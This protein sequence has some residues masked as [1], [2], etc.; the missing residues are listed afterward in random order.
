MKQ[1][2]PIPAGRQVHLPWLDGLRG[3]AALWVLASHV[4]ILCG[5]R[6]IPVLSWGGVAVDLFMLL[7]GFLMAHNYFLR[8]TAEPWHE[9]RTFA[10]F[11][12]RR[13]FRIAPLYYLLLAVAI[14]IGGMLAADRTS[15]AAI[16]PST[17]TPL[18]RYLDGSFDNVVAH[19]SFAFGFLPDYAFRTALPDW[20][21]GLEM[22]FYLVFPFLMLAMLR[23]GA[24][25]ASIVALGLCLLAWA[26]F[27]AYFQR[28]EMPSLIF[29]KLYVFMAGMWIAIARQEGPMTK[30]LLVAI[31]L[32]VM[33]AFAQRHLNMGEPRML[34]LFRICMVAGMFYLMNNGTLPGSGKAARPVR[35]IRKWFSGRVARFL[36]DTSYCA[37]LL[38][39][40]VLLP[41]AG[42]LA[43]MPAYVALPSPL[44]FL[45]CLGLVVPPV[46]LVA[47]GL[48]RT[49]ETGGIHAGRVL[50]K[51]LSRPFGR[52]AKV[53]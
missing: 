43:R 18:H 44:R 52:A 9:P 50:V 25:R 20:S 38:H 2:F 8:R 13:F 41:V 47:W 29:M 40:L 7:S 12:L 28:F 15:I 3:I 31:G 45:I 24:L 11:W 4:Q 37:Y 39:L 49:V 46:Y 27:P 5:M 6:D 51:V 35:E 17:M 22:Q 21:I 30:S 34:V 53:A 19:L 23:I 10:M 42:M 48:F 1:A 33:W 14:A 16:W 36:G 26:A 32:M